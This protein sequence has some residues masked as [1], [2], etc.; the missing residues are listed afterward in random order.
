M[1]RL[2]RPSRGKSKDLGI[3]RMGGEERGSPKAPRYRGKSP[4]LGI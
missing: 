3:N 4:V 2:E 1:K